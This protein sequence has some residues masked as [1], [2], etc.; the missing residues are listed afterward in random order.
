MSNLIIII[1]AII[2]FA[3]F[4]IAHSQHKTP[5][6]S[7]VANMVLG[8][9]SLVLFAPILSVSVNIYTVFAA[10]TLGLP[11]TALVVLC[12]VLIGL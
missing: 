1:T 12:S 8:V 10:L 9:L 7:A 3:I 11:G 2:L 6:K 5:A 4:F